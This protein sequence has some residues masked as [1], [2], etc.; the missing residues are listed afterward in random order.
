ME[1]LFKTQKPLLGGSPAEYVVEIFAGTERAFL[2]RSLALLSVARCV[3]S[4][5]C[6]VMHFSSPHSVQFYS[7]RVRYGPTDHSEPFACGKTNA[8]PH[9][10]APRTAP[11]LFNKKDHTLKRYAQFAWFVFPHSKGWGHPMRLSQLA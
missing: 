11:F 2:F 9:N 10:T 6:S 1:P 5:S 4:R 3:L 8:R 7:T